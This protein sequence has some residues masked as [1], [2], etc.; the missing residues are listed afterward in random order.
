[1][2]RQDSLGPRG[3]GRLDG[4]GI[5]EV[6]GSAVHGHGRSA[7]GD[8]G[9]GARHHGVRGEDD[10]IAGADALGGHENLEGVRRVPDADA[11]THTQVG[12]DAG[13]ELLKILLHDERAAAHDAP[14]DPD[15]LLLMHREGLLVVEERDGARGAIGCHR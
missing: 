14:E 15:V 1:M 5:H 9:A 8:D 10:L 4:S 7:Y 12:R 13:F 3:D 6:V 11:V 2:D